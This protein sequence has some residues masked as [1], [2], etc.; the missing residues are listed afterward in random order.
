MQISSSMFGLIP[1][2][3][4]T[5]SNAGMDMSWMDTT[6]VGAGSSAREQFNSYMKKTPAEKM[7][8]A[9]LQRL[10]VTEEE[11]K[12]MKPEERAAIDKKIQEMIRQELEA[13]ADEKQQT[14]V[15]ADIRV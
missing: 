4:K 6:S 15:L 11:Y 2:T 13:N 14:G 5:A 1:P 3:S 9:M 8:A 10:G 7:H 12:A